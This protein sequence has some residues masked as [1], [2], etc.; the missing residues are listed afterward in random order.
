M[1]VMINLLRKSTL[2][3]LTCLLGACATEPTLT[4]LN[5]GDSVRQMIRAQ[6]Y[7]QSTLSSPSDAP[8]DRTDGQMLEGVLEGYRSEAGTAAPSTGDVL[9]NVGG[10]Q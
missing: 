6:T 5:F 7:D 9:I 8:V 3:A 10:G 1:K 4:E 2:L